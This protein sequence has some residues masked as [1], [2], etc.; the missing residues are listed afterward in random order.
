MLELEEALNCILAAMPAPVS[1]RV[2]LKDA[3]GRVL[4]E[5]VVSPVDLPAFDNSAVDGYAVQAAAV[6]AA[7]EGTPVRLPQIGRVAAGEVFPGEMGR[8]GCVRVFTGA[9]VPQGADAVV[10]QEATRLDPAR[11]GEI[12][13]LEP[14]KPGENVRRQG[15]DVKQGDLLADAGERL[16]AP[17]LCLLA[18][19]GSP[20]AS[21]GCRPRVSLLA[22]G[23]EL[24]E[25]G[26][27]LQPGEIYE[28]NRLALTSLVAS[29]GGLPQ[30]QPIVLDSPGAMRT[31]LEQAL[32]TSDLVVTC[33]GASVGETD[34][35][36]GA[37]EQL[38]G[39]LQ[40]WKVAVKPGK[41]F[42]F[43]RRG[44][45]FLFGLPGNPVSAFVTFLLL[46]R[47]AVLRWQ[48]ARDL[49]LPTHGGIL[50]EALVNADG[51]RHFMRVTVDSAGRVRS[52]G[53][54]G[55]HVFRSLARADGLVDVP[56]QTTLPEGKTVSVCR[57]N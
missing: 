54:Q 5:R 20:D 15:S 55:S 26:A 50:A 9:P 14:A 42:V 27:P 35:V 18:A 44:S 2:P 21:V 37:F 53:K 17:R 36:K 41:P 3:C 38:G 46:V 25:A 51:R 47:P 33:G 40:F 31:A 19:T 29:A 43:G 57:W 6:T 30:V 8:G 4:A 10:M 39:E 1:E 56:P 22:T 49:S 16:T 24:K 7:G 34:Y 48:G 13:F 45:Q 52:A 23:S 11:E 12:L 32:A 28:S